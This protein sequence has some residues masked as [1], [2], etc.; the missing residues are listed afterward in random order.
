MK[1]K[2]SLS[3]GKKQWVRERLD[4]HPQKLGF[5]ACVIFATFLSSLLHA[6]PVF[7]PGFSA[8]RMATGTVSAPVAAALAPD[9]RFFVVEQA[10]NVRIIKNNVLLATPFVSL[11]VD[12]QGERG[13]VGIAVDPDFLVNKYI[14]VYYTVPASAGNPA[15]NRISRFTA[16]NDTA[17]PG[18]GTVILNLDPLGASLIHNGGALHFGKDGKLY[19]AVGD[20]ATN[21]PAQSLDSYHGKILRINKDG[22]APPDNPFPTGSEQRKRVWA[23]GLRNPFTFNVD[24]ETGK[25]FVNDVGGSSWEEINDATLPGRNFG[26][27]STEGKFNQASFPTFT[28]PVYAYAHGTGDGV[29]CAIVGGAFISPSNPLYPS[30]YRGKYLFQESCNNWLNILDLSGPSPV[31]SPFATQV[32]TNSLGLMTEIDGYM[33]YLHRGGGALY[34]IV[35]DG[36]ILPTITNHPANVSVVVGQPATFSVTAVGTPPLGYQWQKNGV[37]ISGAT[38][39]TFAI[40]QCTLANS[41]NYRVIVTNA[42]GSATSNVATLSV[43]DNALPTAEI[44]TPTG[45]DPYIAGTTINFSGRGTDPEDGVLPPASM[46]WHIDFHH[47]VH[48]HD[49][50]PRVGISSGSFTI[51]QVGETSANVWYR[52]TLEVTDSEGF[53]SEDFVD[54]FPL[55]ST[56][57]FNTNPA[58]LQILLDGQ[59]FSTPGSVVSVE[60][61]IRT[62]GTPSVQ[63]LGN[64]AYVFESWTHGGPQNQSITTPSADITYTANFRR[65]ET[66]FYRALNLNGAALTI[67]G[68]SW[69]S[70]IGAANFS[71]TASG[72]LFSGQSIPLI[73]STDA[74][75]ATMIRSSIWGNT[76]NLNM[77]AVPSG[78]YQVWLYVWEDNFSAT[79][80]I[81]L[82]GSVVRSNFVSGGA[83]AW[84]KLGPYPV[85]ITDGAI[86]VSTNGGHANVSG[87]EVWTAGTPP[88][89]QLPVVANPIVDQT[90]S[91]GAAF[92]YT[93]PANTFSD[94]DPGTTLTYTATLSG[95][96]ALPGWLSFSAGTRNFSGTPGS[97]DVG[98]LNIWVTAS[99]GAGGPVSDV[100]TLT[101]NDVP[102]ASF[103]RAINL[104]GPSLSIDGNNWEAS[105]SAAN[106]GYTTDRG[107]YANQSITL[108]P[109]TDANR[110]TMIRSSIWG[111]NVTLTVGSVPAGTYDVWVYVWE[112]N[113]PVTYSIFLEG[114]VVQANYN[115]GSAGTWRKLGPF[116]A[117]ISDGT[118]NVSLN[119]VQVTVSGVEVWTAQS[120]SSGQRVAILGPESG[121]MHPE[122][123][124]QDI[125]AVWSFYP[126]PFSTK[127]TI[128]YTATQ[129][130]LTGITL[131]DVRGVKMWSNPEKYV[132]IGHKETVEIETSSFEYGVYVLELING[133]GVKRQKVVKIN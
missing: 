10:G 5:W 26:W 2:N 1:S 55:K 31:R 109:A 56:L 30:V 8:M 64:D 21:T 76:V 70:S 65:Q 101:V 117:T 47:D 73:P 112:D 78:G 97:G 127:A 40:S 18:S 120:G 128:V 25:I 9:G 46:T 91:E 98:T 58:G 126:N 113:F 82:E 119:G 60:G 85:T 57:S 106:F 54:I 102:S 15:R 41:G 114:N 61:V 77:T 105:A 100:F 116:R 53:T 131:Y 81:S 99:D 132:D 72:G 107:L 4:I 123:E 19:V 20:N 89:N 71:Y 12:S 11:T 74:N 37:N 42:G 88:P 124:E 103:Y 95:G 33:Y 48:H 24:H 44:L 62:I 129:A 29:G 90:A 13:M 104:N 84:T 45:N 22:S 93:F 17:A 110:A 96:G 67:D 122:N 130:G 87:L 28:N 49:E 133:R 118:I 94:P 23:L 108:I 14:Y 16:T 51:P 59:P 50:A 66:T 79:Y 52:I 68:N 69:Q 63:N 7:P 27:P 43:I 35:Y 36:G 92:N 34:K 6:Q 115:S 86:N 39:A 3:E 121:E 83:G 111:Y 38:S 125:D 75:R 80:S 32:H